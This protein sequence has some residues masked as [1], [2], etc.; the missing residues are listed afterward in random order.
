MIYTP[1]MASI[2]L[3]GV[4]G[5]DFVGRDSFMFQ[6][7]W[8]I[9]SPSK[10]H[11][12]ISIDVANV[13]TGDDTEMTWSNA[14]SYCQNRSAELPTRERLDLINSKSFSGS[15]VYWTSQT[16]G[17]QVY[18]LYVFGNTMGL[19]DKDDTAYPH[20]VTENYIIN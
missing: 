8:L 1:E 2:A 7:D 20:C 15:E 13:S 14:T 10:K 4:I 12:T 9:G 5:N 6:A 18:A 11:V 3:G 17:D 19:K 16:S